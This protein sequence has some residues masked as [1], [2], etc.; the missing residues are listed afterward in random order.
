[1]MKNQPISAMEKGLTAQ[2]TNRV[3][4]MPFFCWRTSL[5]ALKSIFISI[6]MIITQIS[7][8]TG[9]LTLAT[10]RAPTAWAAC[11]TTRPRMVPATMHRNTH[12]VR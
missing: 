8:P 9:I 12:R 7:R 4:N 2:L 1:M 6:G 5:I 3:T 10:S 11:G